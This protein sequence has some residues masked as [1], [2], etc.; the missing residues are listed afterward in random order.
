[1]GQRLGIRDIIYRHEFHIF[2][3]ISGPVHKPTDSSKTID[4][5]LYRH[6]NLLEFYSSLIK[7]IVFCQYILSQI[8]FDFIFVKCMFSGTEDINLTILVVSMKATGISIQI[9]NNCSPA[10]KH[11]HFRL[12]TIIK[13]TRFHRPNQNSF[14]C[15]APP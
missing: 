3:F 12:N 13:V 4:G 2:I 9:V 11:P 5:N 8:L 1:M 6:I 14:I 15:R 10:L 7:G